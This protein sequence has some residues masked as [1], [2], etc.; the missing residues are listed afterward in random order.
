[1]SSTKGK[2][3]GRSSKS[4]PENQTVDVA[5]TADPSVGENK[6]ADYA[7][8][9]FLKFASVCYNKGFIDLVDLV[10]NENFKTFYAVVCTASYQA[11]REDPSRKEIE[12]YILACVPRDVMK[13]LIAD[14]LLNTNVCL[15]KENE[16]GSDIELT[17]VFDKKRDANMDN[18]INV[19]IEYFIG[20]VYIKGEDEPLQA[21]QIHKM[22]VYDDLESSYKRY[23]SFQHDFDSKMYGKM[24]DGDGLNRKLVYDG[25]A[26]DIMATI[27]AHPLNFHGKD[28]NVI[29]DILSS[30]VDE[31]GVATTKFEC[32]NAITKVMNRF[33]LRANPNI[34]V[35]NL[36]NND[37][38]AAAAPEEPPAPT[39]TME[40]EP[41]A[42]PAALADTADD[43]PPSKNGKKRPQSEQD[44]PESDKS[45]DDKED[46]AAKPPAPAPAAPAAPA[47]ATTA[48]GR[49]R[50]AAVKNPPKKAKQGTTADA[51]AATKSEKRNTLDVML[52]TK[53]EKIYDVLKSIKMKRHSQI[54]Q[55][56]TIQRGDQKIKVFGAKHTSMPDQKFDWMLLALSSYARTVSPTVFAPLID[57]TISKFRD[58][59]IHTPKT[60]AKHE[61]MTKV[62]DNTD[63]MPFMLLQL[64]KILHIQHISN[65]KELTYR[66]EA[67][68]ALAKELANA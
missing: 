13:T 55:Y 12:R 53:F 11:C 54:K 19:L 20:L 67:K 31:G 38:P 18:L 47:P 3:K 50:S 48:K 10:Q 63:I 56:G 58:E 30:V 44:V 21:H 16:R 68:W 7:Y 32:E 42:A 4:N 62:A 57:D 17:P 34:K 65:I 39:T 22:F 40:I 46:G 66:L 15:K 27:L 29:C 5:A 14:C 24:F 28:Q 25:T 43:N 52:S 35:P 1:M 8:F 61:S 36:D 23:K 2:G 49:K 6:R 33:M 45:D 51:A 60:V 26:V 64:S 41:T 59:L 9:R 37:K